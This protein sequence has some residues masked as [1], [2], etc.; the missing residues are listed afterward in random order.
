MM[1]VEMLHGAFVATDASGGKHSAD[2]WLRRVGFGMFLIGSGFELLGAIG[3]SV[4]EAQMVNRIECFA[5]LL[6]RG[7]AEVITDRLYVQK[8]LAQ[9]EQ[10]GLPDPH[11]D[12]WGL[13][14]QA[15]RDKEQDVHN[16][17]VGSHS[18]S[19]QVYSEG[20]LVKH[21]WGN[22]QAGGLGD[23]MDGP[24]LRSGL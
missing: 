17:E 12:L 13:L 2:P 7:G 14:Q 10:T 23:Q 11:V 19:A 22:L 1:V 15:Q 20:I 24:S 8:P 5:V 4:P 6:A 9:D 18:T 16:L 3:G 21:W